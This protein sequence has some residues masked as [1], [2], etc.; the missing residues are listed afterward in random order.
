MES[1]FLLW[2]THVHPDTEYEDEKL[3]GVYRTQRSA[4]E[5]LERVKVAPGF[6]DSPHGFEISKYILDKDHWIE[7]FT[8]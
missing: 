1:V 7:G 2:H 5:A 8:L 3:I 6:R 4:E